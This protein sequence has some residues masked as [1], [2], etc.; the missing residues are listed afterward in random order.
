MHTVLIVVVDILIFGLGWW[1][2]S[3]FT[4]ES[5]FKDTYVYFRKK[6]LTP[7]QSYAEIKEIVKT[8]ADE[9]LYPDAE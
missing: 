5:I 9:Y 8:D 2:G 4:G 7:E 1:R 3:K 6:G